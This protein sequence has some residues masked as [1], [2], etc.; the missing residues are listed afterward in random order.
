VDDD[1]RSF[2]WGLWGIGPLLLL[3]LLG[4][5]ARGQELT[6]EAVLSSLE[7]SKR[8]LVSQQLE[9]GSWTVDPYG[10]IG[11][12][13]LA[14]LALINAGMTEDD[15]AVARG[16]GYLRSLPERNFRSGQWQVYQVSL[17][18]MALSA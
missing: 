3:I 12:T 8:F 10:A 11:P 5:G 1:M 17:A 4:S 18:I 16:L 14:L 13:G 7:N 15:P 2:S 9:N 6:S